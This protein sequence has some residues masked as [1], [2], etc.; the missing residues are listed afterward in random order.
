[1]AEALEHS[2]SLSRYSRNCYL[3]HLFRVPFQS[4]NL[5]LTFRRMLFQSFVMIKVDAAHGTFIFFAATRG[6]SAGKEKLVDHV[7]CP[8]MTTRVT[9][10]SLIL[11]SGLRWLRFV[12]F[13]RVHTDGNV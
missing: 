5:S 13:C 9:I 7:S 12:F 6:G 10:C 4:V 8:P 2:R 1:M 3:K 11:L